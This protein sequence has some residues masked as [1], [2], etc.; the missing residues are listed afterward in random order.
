MGL[1]TASL[2]DREK[3]A[4]TNCPFG[5]GTIIVSGK[6]QPLEMARHKHVCPQRPTANLTKDTPRGTNFTT[7]GQSSKPPLEFTH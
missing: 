6:Y 3:L 2:F 1:E 5:C 4:S 7:I